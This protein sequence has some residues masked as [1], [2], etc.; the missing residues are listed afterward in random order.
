M[1]RLFLQK[2]KRRVV[3]VIRPVDAQTANVIANGPDRAQKLPLFHGESANCEIDRCALLEQQQSFKQR[4]GI[5]AARHSDGD[6]VAIPDH[7]E[8]VNR[9]TDFPQQSFFQIH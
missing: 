3:G 6:A 9:F 7:F 4:H 5:F 1:I 8:A 2:T